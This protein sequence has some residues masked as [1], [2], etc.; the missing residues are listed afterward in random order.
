MQ[1]MANHRQV[2]RTK[3]VNVILIQEGRTLKEG[4]LKRSLLQQ[5]ENS[6]LWQFVTG[7][8]VFGQRKKIIVL[9]SAV[10][11]E[12]FFLLGCVKLGAMNGMSM[13]SLLLW[14][15]TPFWIK[16]SFTHFHTTKIINL[17][18]FYLNFFLFFV[19]YKYF[20]RKPNRKY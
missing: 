9:P 5:S 7:W 16:F 19:N 1:T 8:V 11:K 10:C 3:E 13:K 4:V 18:F 20:I 6:G 2:Q 12:S 17:S 14:F 15:L